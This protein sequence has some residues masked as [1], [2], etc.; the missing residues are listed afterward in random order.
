M[1]KKKITLS[2]LEVKSF[3]TEERSAITGGRRAK[4]KGHSCLG[5]GPNIC[6]DSADCPISMFQTCP[7]DI[8][9][10]ECGCT[11]AHCVVTERC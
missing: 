8:F 3:V 2:S 4:T 5:T 6:Y 11:D 1:K 9:K 10:S 7:T